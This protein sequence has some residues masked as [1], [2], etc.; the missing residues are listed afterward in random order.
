[1][2]ALQGPRWLLDRITVNSVTSSYSII[3]ESVIGVSPEQPRSIAVD[4]VKVS[5][6]AC[7]PRGFCDFE[8]DLCGWYNSI[9]EGK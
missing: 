8:T 5:S 7:P 4:D 6:G 2:F 9:G 3:F 1:M